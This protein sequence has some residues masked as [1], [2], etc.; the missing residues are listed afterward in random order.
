MT[1]H[2]TKSGIPAAARR[3]LLSSAAG[4]A[5]LA[6]GMT[7]ATAQIDEI[8]VYAQKREQ[9]LQDVPISISAFD[10]DFL[11]D[12]N[13]TDVFDLQRFT[14]G[15][16]VTQSQ[17]AGQNQFSIRGVG[18]SSNNF[19]LESSV[20][21]FVDGVF[22]QRQAS[23]ISDI[24]DVESIE[25]LRGP[26][27]TLFGKNTSSGAIQ[28]RTVAP[29]NEFGGY[30]EVSGGNFDFITANGAINIPIVDGV[31]ATRLTGSI[32]KRD[33]Y[34]E[35][36][37]TGTDTND[38]D[39]YSFRGQLLFTPTEQLSIRII[40]DVS[41]LDEICCSAVNV[42]D[43]PADTT[44]GFL[45]ALPDIL[46]A[47]AGFVSFTNNIETLGGQVIL[48]DRFNDDVVATDLDPFINIKEYGISGEI[49]WDLGGHTIT[50]ITAY[51]SFDQV[52]AVD[53][54]FT[55]LDSLRF[56]GSDVEQTVFTQ[57]LRIANNDG[58]RFNWVLGGYFFTQDLDNVTTLLGGADLN[59]V[60]AAGLLVG[61]LL[62]AFPEGEGSINNVQ[63]DQRSFAFFGQTDWNVTDDLVL[64]GGI[65]YTR[66]RKLISAEF[67]ETVP[68][69]TEVAPGVFLPT[70][71]GFNAF[72]PFSFLVPDVDAE[73]TD[74]QVTGT[75][76]IS[77]FWTP[78]FL[79]YASFGRGYK[80]AGT[81]TDRISP[82]TGA[83]QLFDAETSTSWEVGA[84][85]TLFNKKVQVN[86]SLFRT[87]FNDFQANSFVGTGFVLQNAGDITTRGGE[88][89]IF[90]A[91]TEWLTLQTGL[92]IVDAEFTSFEDGE[93]IRT[94]LFDSPDGF[95]F[96][97]CD[98]TGNTV[99]L[100]PLVQ[101]T[102]SAQ[103][104]QPINDVIEA[105]GRVDLSYRTDTE[106]LNSNDPNAETDSYT[107]VNL[108]AG[109]TLFEDSVDLSV[110]VKNVFD[111][112]F[113]AN[114]FSS[115]GREGSLSGFHTEPRFW[116]AT[117]RYKF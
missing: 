43:G 12:A 10:A 19:G 45:A 111:E 30:A 37:V 52:G 116:G 36:I 71:A 23:G 27:G 67:N 8:L 91:P 80:S 60:L 5:V 54:D 47:P 109:V 33:G 28:F 2:Q 108:R 103:V 39:R 26:Q 24:V 14:P 101:L 85:T 105:Y 40:G 94:P 9:S 89:E 16:T 4:I 99:P 59:D 7:S 51:R 110:W 77:Y 65:R 46:T 31:L 70:A 18:T 69:F 112:D 44:A 113:T 72:T 68:E 106:Q 98:N 56:S 34:V 75:G 79:T 107:L 104:N 76:K 74:Q 32:T 95:D 15:L 22:R 35:N 25:I 87:K 102:A 92:G 82:A 57:E 38:R 96:I 84:K 97:V 41:E 6:G 81:N 63:Q 90:A 1:D 3:V 88:L 21:I 66:E 114:N 64:T 73:L 55:S 100:T 86:A 117:G 61:G 115:V 17:T 62:P 78:D 48:A 20:G 53:A 13:I 29:K 49:N 93:C 58:E 83:P 11:D 42:F 50:S